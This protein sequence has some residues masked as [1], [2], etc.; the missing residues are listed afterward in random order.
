MHARTHAQA[1][2]NA[3]AYGPTASYADVCPE[4]C[5]VIRCPD[6]TTTQHPTA[7][8]AATTAAAVLGSNSTSVPSSL[9]DPNVTIGCGVAGISIATLGAAAMAA[10]VSV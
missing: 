1:A 6:E 4:V 2:V 7:P 3:S 10:V 9:S 8:G 5:G